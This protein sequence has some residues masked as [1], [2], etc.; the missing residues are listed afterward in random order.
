MGEHDACFGIRSGEL[1]EGVEGGEADLVLG[2]VGIE[3][4]WFVREYVDGD[5]CFTGED[6]AGRS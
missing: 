3:A 6:G 1:G 5:N 2:N 4:S